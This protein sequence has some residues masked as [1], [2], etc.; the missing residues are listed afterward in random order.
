CFSDGGER[1]A[2][3]ESVK[4][5][6]VILL[7]LQRGEI[8]QDPAVAKKAQDRLQQRA[9]Q[10]TSSNNMKQLGLAMHIYHDANKHPP[11]HAIYSKDGKPLLS[12]R[13]AVLPY[14]EQNELYQQFKF[15]EPWDS[16]H[17]KKLLEKMPQLYAPVRGKTK[18]PYA[19]YY[20]VFTGPDA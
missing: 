5:K 10:L 13:V 12:W 7:V 11:A 17:N 3:F 19:T 16:A 6:S 4:G 14:I 1:P 9:Q 15:D 2:A 18:V 20:Q 8:K